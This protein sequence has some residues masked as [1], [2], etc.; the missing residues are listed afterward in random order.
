M[1]GIA[2]IVSDRSPGEQDRATVGRML[3]RLAHRGP[4]GEGQW[5]DGPVGLGHRRLAIIDLATGAQPMSNEDETVWIV[6]NG[7]ITDT[8][9][10]HVDGAV[11]MAR[12]TEPDVD[13][14]D[15]QEQIFRCA[16]LY[17][18]SWQGKGTVRIGFRDG[19]VVELADVR[20]PV[21]EPRSSV[22]TTPV[23]LL[24]LVALAVLVGRR[25]A[26]KAA[27]QQDQP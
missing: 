7:E 23:I 24:V 19:G 26:A 11:G 25:R 4:D 17:Q 21:R 9:A 22:W 3:N 16:I 18:D 14:R 12:S 15:G 1:C 8:N 10:T 6:C 27:E 20:V 5:L 13:I 2:G